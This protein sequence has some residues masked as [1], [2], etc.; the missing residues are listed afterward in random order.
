MK[1]TLFLFLVLVGALACSRASGAIINGGF[2]TGDLSGWFGSGGA[3]VQSGSPYPGG[4]YY[5]SID[6][7]PLGAPSQLTQIFSIAGPSLLSFQYYLDVTG[8]AFV[9]YGLVK[10]DTLEPTVLIAEAPNDGENVSELFDPPDFIPSFEYKITQPGSY[11]FVVLASAKNGGAAHA[12]LDNV[13]LLAVPEPS[14][15]AMALG[16]VAA[17]ICCGR[18]W[19]RRSSR[20]K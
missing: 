19:M 17:L 15:W 6:A 11:A 20:A 9:S 5:A 7:V 8:P 13:K 4:N 3:S 10:V 18:S 2:E 1:R 14:A 12:E 16:G